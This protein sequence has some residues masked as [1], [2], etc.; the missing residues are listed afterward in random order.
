MKR[1]YLAIVLCLVIFP[2]S[3][4]SIAQD[5]ARVHRVH[6]QG[7]KPLKGKKHKKVKPAMSK[8]EAQRLATKKMLLQRTLKEKN[9]HI[10]DSLKHK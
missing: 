2:F 9:F 1:R 10:A 5:T 6:E 7:Q 8:K 4:L 3:V